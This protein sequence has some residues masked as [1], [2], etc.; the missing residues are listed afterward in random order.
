MSDIHEHNTIS[1]Y[2]FLFTVYNYICALLHN[3]AYSAL[4]IYQSYVQLCRGLQS[5]V[6]SQTAS[7]HGG[8]EAVWL[9]KTSTGQGSVT[10]DLAPSG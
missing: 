1:I 9:R 4:I 6:Y 2:I 3:I 8:E 5:C 10:I 7:S